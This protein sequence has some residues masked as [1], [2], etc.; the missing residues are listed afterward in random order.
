MKPT[1]CPS[2]GGV[3]EKRRLE[4]MHHGEVV[5]DLCFSCQGIWFDDFESVQI[6]PGG[7]LELFNLLH[8]HR[9]DLRQPLADP[10]RC[11]RCK[12]KLL[13]GM[14]VAKHGGRFNYHRC[15]QKHGRFITFAQFMI[16]K[17]FV[18]QLSATEITELSA[19]VGIIR[20]N[21]C[22][23]PV[24]IRKDHVCGHCRSP[25][26]ILDPEAVENALARYKN[27]EE[28]RTTRDV[29]MLGD[30]IVMRER[31][32]SRQKRMG[33]D[34]KIELTDVADL[35]GTGLDLLFTLLRR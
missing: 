3:M 22:G 16:E 35:F 20:C 12:E 9:D 19:K 33:L 10:L 7:I 32:K 24:D 26:S 28:K 2:C 15:L 11:P 17:G 29:E 6:T 34:E 27:A 4:R 8:Q 13:H 14:D 31:E 25:I 23:A 18:R 30:A 5:I 1:P 21:A